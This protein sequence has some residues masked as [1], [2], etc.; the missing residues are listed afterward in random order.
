MHGGAS[1]DSVCARRDS[2]P[3]PSAPE[4]AP[5]SDHQRWPVSFQALTWVAGR[6]GPASDGP[7]VTT[8]VTTVVLRRCPGEKR[9][10][11]RASGAHRSITGVARRIQKTY[12][13]PS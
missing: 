8:V 2:N 9:P 7:V 13:A 6:P 4:A 10:P 11:V 1:G 5:A 12:R 3:R